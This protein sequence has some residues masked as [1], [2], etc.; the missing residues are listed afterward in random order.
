[1]VKSWP[2]YMGTY[3]AIV[4]EHGI[5][6][7]AKAGLPQFVIRVVLSEYYDP[8]QDEWFDVSD[9]NWVMNAYL[10]LYGREGGQED[11]EI[12]ET[13]NH[14]QVCKVFDWDG[15]GFEYLTT[16]EK[17]SGKVI[18]V[19]VAENTYEG[20]KAPVQIE[21]IDTEDADPNS[22]LQCLDSGQ[23]KALE[24]EFAHLW[25]NKKAIPP[26]ASAKKVL[27]L[28]KQPP[29]E[30]KEDRKK[31]LLEKSKRLRKEAMKAP[32]KK[33]EPPAKKT[34]E[35]PVPVNYSKKQAWSDI[36]E[37]RAEECTDD[38]QK[39]AWDA[40]IAETAPDGDEDKLDAAGWWAVKEA[41]IA[42]IGQF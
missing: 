14:Q 26:A 34:E 9:N 22:G 36:I 30:T 32:P 4:V 5:K 20:A 29:A 35:S 37:L 40:A 19:R 24:V 27:L 8:K 6:K 41:V 2:D 42:D 31:N 25:K 11:S 17:F 28:K 10:T 12:I 1:M 18:Q 7:T 38:Q 39:A 21:W 13:L 23:V 15:C 3:K 33:K 16:P